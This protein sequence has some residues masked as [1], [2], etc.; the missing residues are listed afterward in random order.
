MNLIKLTQNS[1]VCQRKCVLL[2]TGKSNNTIIIE[3]FIIPKK[4]KCVLII[5]STTGNNQHGCSGKLHCL[6]WSLS[7]LC[8]FSNCEC[9]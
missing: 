8:V 2:F 3:A 9:I 4:V 1:Y 7:T 6:R 5:L